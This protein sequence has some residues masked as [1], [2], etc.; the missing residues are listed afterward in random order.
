MYLTWCPSPGLSASLFTHT[1]SNFQS[2]EPH[3]RGKHIFLVPWLLFMFTLRKTRPRR[4]LWQIMLTVLGCH[5]GSRMALNIFNLSTSVSWNI[6]ISGEP[7]TPCHV[8]TVSKTSPCG[9]RRSLTLIVPKINNRMHSTGLC[10]RNRLETNYKC[11][12]HICEEVLINYECRASLP[13]T[14]LLHSLLIYFYRRAAFSQSIAVRGSFLSL[15]QPSF[16]TVSGFE[17]DIAIIA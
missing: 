16:I 7:L 6:V 17:I 14:F 10:H 4:Y 11:I 3:L 15:F 8:T 9:T 2:G 13:S 1:T 5:L 12:L